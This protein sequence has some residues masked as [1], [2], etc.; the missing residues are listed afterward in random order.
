ML[1]LKD[2]LIE[3]AKVVNTLPQTELKDGTTTYNV[4]G[5]PANRK[6]KQVEAEIDLACYSQKNST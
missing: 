2:A 4:P 6:L 5:T 1:N 3:L